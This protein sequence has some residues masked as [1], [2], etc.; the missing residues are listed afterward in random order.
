MEFP[1]GE[2]LNERWTHLRRDGELPIRLAVVRYRKRMTQSGVKPSTSTS[3][4][5]G[6]KNAPNL[7]A[8]LGNE[9]WISEPQALEGTVRAKRARAARLPQRLRR[10]VA[11][12]CD[13]QRR[14]AGYV[15]MRR[16]AQRCLP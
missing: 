9:R 15:T 14:V 12:W 11:I 6:L 3:T 16:G 7:I 5:Q 8:H 2:I 10:C 4:F 1:D 13:A